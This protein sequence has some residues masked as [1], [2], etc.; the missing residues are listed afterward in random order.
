MSVEGISIYRQEGQRKEPNI[1]CLKRNSF[2]NFIFVILIGVIVVLT[3]VTI[4][5]GV[6]KSD[7]SSEEKEG[8]QKYFSSTVS[9][10]AWEKYKKA[11]KY[12]LKKLQSFVHL[13]KLF[14]IF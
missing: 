4:V 10:E 13:N 1:G 7:S 14:L 2:P 11:K 5:V 6:T 12:L 3:T 9:S 8:G